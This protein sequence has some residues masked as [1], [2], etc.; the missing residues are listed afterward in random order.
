VD[1]APESETLLNLLVQWDELRQQGK[2]AT[3]EELCPGDARLQALLRERLARRQRLHVALDLPARTLHDQVARAAPLPVIDGYDMGELLGRGGMGLVYKAVDKALKREVAL[4]IVWSGAHAS[5]EER[6]RFRTEAEAVARLHD[7]GIVQ[8]YE[9]GEQAGCPYLALEFV[10]GGTL[11]QQLDGTPLPPR[12]AAELLLDL[13]RAV[14]HAHEQGIVHRD[15]KPANVLLTET[16]VAKIADFGLAKLLDVELGHTHTGAV[17][18]SP[19][20]MA[21]EQAEGN[22]RAIGPATDVYALGAI[23]YELL[24]GRPPFKAETTMDTLLQVKFTDPVSPT[25][26]QPKLSRDLATICLRCLQK[27][28][29]QRYASA[30]A[31]AE[32]L[33]RFLEGQPIRARPVG[34]LARTIKW[35]RRRPAVAALGAGIF[36]I[37]ALGFVGVTWQWREAENARTMA[38]EARRTAEDRLYF[39]RIALAHQAWRGYQVGQADRL[40]DECIPT[41]DQE[42]RRSWEWQYLRRLS[43][44]AQFTLTGHTLGVQGVAFSRDGRLLASCSGEWRGE[45]PGEILVWDAATGKLLHTF[46]GHERGVNNVAFAPDGRLLA[47]VG[48]DWT[49]RLWDLTRP[50]D[51]PVVLKSDDGA[52]NVA[53][54]P[55][56]SLLAATY[57]NRVV[58]I[59]DVKSRTLLGT[60]VKHVNNVFAVAFHPTERKI[61]TAGGSDDT[62]QIWDPDTGRDLGSLR[63]NTD[64]R[65]VAYSAD[66]TLLAAASFTGVVTVWDLSRPGAEATT[67]HLYA[68]PVLNLAFRPNSHDLAWCTLTGR[69]QI[70]DAR[71]GAEVRTF[72][73]HDGSVARLAFSPDG[74]RLA[75]AGADRR[76]RVWRMD[77]PQEVSSYWR[78]GGWNYDCAFSPDSKYLAM[79]G[80]I[81]QSRP[82]GH[83]SVRLWD[84]DEQRW[85][86]EFQWTDYLTSVAYGRDQ[87]AAGSEDGTAVIWDAATAAVRHELKGHRGVVTGVAYSPDGRRLVTAGADGTVRWW[88]TDTAQEILTVPGNGTPLS[89]VAYSPDGR[90][91]AAAGADPTVRVWDAATGRE[92]HSLRGHAADVTCVVFSPDGQ[93][94]ASADLDLVVRLW[95]VRTGKEDAPRKEPIHLDGP[96]PEK[97]RKPWDRG[98]PLAPRI[99]FSADGRRLASINAGQPVQLWDVATRLEVLTLPVEQSAFQCVAFS[100]DGRWLAAV[101]GVWFHV[102]DAGCTRPADHAPTS[103]DAPK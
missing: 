101:A 99:A 7:P 86:K 102:W 82:T 4:K 67:H 2:T 78:P 27:E 61:A 89:G 35:V 55:N 90:L 74:Q 15:L 22:V 36:L 75:S 52:T 63:W 50:D 65:S 68:G 95:D 100:R 47:S 70:I 54:S 32:D 41:G 96:E 71:T 85:V 37:M 3:P 48:D 46:R 13:A 6:A 80:G 94:L 51:A 83:K 17:L 12:R 45:H 62:V 49:L 91:V 1:A 14:Q 103:G 59:W 26:L 34:M 11:A 66:G 38:Q 8:I 9:V 92:V 93:R 30:L 23:L 10:G 42:D 60:H 97:M 56:G 5:A 28:P 20:Y 88:D 43:R 79:A 58:R 24:T 72:H 76:V 53:F 21:P 44:A 81:S 73:G 57:S 40:L 31:L 64:V 19:S 87:L 16:G 84:L 29:R 98:R 33:H 18:G 25:H 77:A 39:N 69:I